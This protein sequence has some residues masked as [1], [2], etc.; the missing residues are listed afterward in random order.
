[1]RGL[2]DD[3]G[4]KKESGVIRCGRS[5]LVYTRTFSPAS[6]MSTALEVNSRAGTSRPLHRSRRLSSTRLPGMSIFSRHQPWKSQQQ[7][8]TLNPPSPLFL[9][10]IELGLYRIT[11][12]LQNTPQTWK[13]I[14]V[15]GTNGKGS[16]CAYLSAMLHAAGRSCARFNSPHFIDRWDC[17][18]VNE[19]PISETSFLDA[20]ISVKERDQSRQVGATEFELLT[21]TAFEIMNRE[22]VEFGIIEVGMGGL[23]DATNAMK[24]KAV[25]V[26]TKIG[27]DHQFMLGD[28]IEDIALQK[29]GIMR[30]AVPCIVDRSNQ[31]SVLHVVEEHAK[32]TGAPLIYSPVLSDLSGQFEPHQAQNIAGALEA[33]R[34]ACPSEDASPQRWLPIISKAHIPGRLQRLDQ[35]SKRLLVDGA[36]NVQSAEVLAQYVNKHLREDG[37]QPVIWVLAASAGKD[38]SGILRVLLKPND[39]VTAAQFGPVDGMPWVRPQEPRDILGAAQE[40]DAVTFE[41]DPE[42]GIE[43]IVKEAL[44]KDRPVVVAG[45]LYLVSDFLRSLRNKST[46]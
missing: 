15:A 18:T 25:T 22:N 44:S 37:L 34:L 8:T 46:I 43:T 28:T 2:E 12:L 31:P 33:F 7:S 5:R 26:I 39:H 13:A 42:A 23:L 30:K 41:S 14:H 35:G 32:A 24:D 1:M 6:E 3:V 17:I 36:H 45:S 27:L 16:T 4:R 38:V 20:E 9:T 29:A 11:R 21:A 40:C 19:K 10:M